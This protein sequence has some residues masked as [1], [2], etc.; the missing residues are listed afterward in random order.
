MRTTEMFSKPETIYLGGGTPSFLPITLLDRLVRGIAE[1]MDVSRVGEWT[2]ECNPDDVSPE[3]AE[4]LSSSPINRVSM[5]VQTFSNERLR[6]LC[7]RHSSKQVGEAVSLIRRAG[8]Q[9]LSLDLMY[10]FPN[11]T[12]EEWKADITDCLA[13]RPEHISAY[14][15]MYEE[16]TPLFSMLEKGI[17]AEIDED[18]SLTMFEVLV[19]SLAEAGYD[20]YEI[21]NF[22]LPG[23]QSCH[24]SNYW[25]QVPY[26][27]IGAG[28]HS[29]D[30]SQRWNNVC[31]IEDYISS[32]EAGTV[33]SEYEETTPEI[34][35]ELESIVI[36]T[37]EEKQEEPKQEPPVI[38]Q[39]EEMSDEEE[40]PKRNEM[41]LYYWP[42]LPKEHCHRWTIETAVMFE[43]L[44]LDCNI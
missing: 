29:Y 19:D 17:V 20:H 8:I 38:P 21:S 36:E 27:G 23:R 34:P 13:L 42:I 28:A 10:G 15:L 41:I 16:G 5:G 25:Q 32:V 18:L 43:L 9:N 24:N 40:K 4:W 6:W 22:S 7:R 14:S 44:V 30:L 11:Q 39:V 31:N 3:L 26:L 35:P 1:R 2:I 12:I 37:V 33:E